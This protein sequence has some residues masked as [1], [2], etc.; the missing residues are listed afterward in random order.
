[1]G[2]ANK[3]VGGERPGMR[4]LAAGL[5]PDVEECEAFSGGLREP[6]AARKRLKKPMVMG[7]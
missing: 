4:G 1:M 3:F 7:Y 5:S 2:T 6:D